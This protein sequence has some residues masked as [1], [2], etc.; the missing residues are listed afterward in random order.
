M[1]PFTAKMESLCQVTSLVK[2]YT[3]AFCSFPIHKKYGRFC[4]RNVQNKKIEGQKATLCHI[5]DL[6]TRR[7]PV[8]V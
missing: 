4:G 5:S 3:D 7:I 2:K 6:W 8:R 1:Q